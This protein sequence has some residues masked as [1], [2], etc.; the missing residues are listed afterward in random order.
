MLYISSKLC[1]RMYYEIR[2][3][4]GCSL[5]GYFSAF[6][7][8]GKFKELMFGWFRSQW[9]SLGWYKTVTLKSFRHI[10]AISVHLQLQKRWKEV[11]LKK[12]LK[13]NC[14]RTFPFSSNTWKQ[15]KVST[16]ISRSHLSHFV[17]K[18]YLSFQNLTRWV[19]S[20]MAATSHTQLF[21]MKLTDIN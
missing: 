14:S 5:V 13:V 4:S 3:K 9:I 11:S 16:E 8:Y 10:S 15:L 19:Q 2:T 1:L 18:K 20:H 6:S 21:K 12:W 7:Q 17:L